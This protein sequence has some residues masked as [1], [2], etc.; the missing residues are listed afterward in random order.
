MPPESVFQSAK[1]PNPGGRKKF[2]RAW[3]K[4]RPPA[5]GKAFGGTQI[6]TGIW[7]RCA[8]ETRMSQKPERTAP[9]HNHSP[10]GKDQPTLSR[11]VRSKIGQ[12]LRAM[13]DDVVSQG[14]PDR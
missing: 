8:G 6:F 14:V 4:T 13:Y 2:H 10:A 5:L 11:D 1:M 3:N 9:M 12:Q 7:A